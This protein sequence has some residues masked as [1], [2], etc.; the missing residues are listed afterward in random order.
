MEVTKHTFVRTPGECI[1]ELNFD[2]GV[3]YFDNLEV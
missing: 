1:E 2:K 3:K